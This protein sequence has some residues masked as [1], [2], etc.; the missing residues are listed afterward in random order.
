MCFNALM[1][2]N[3]PPHRLVGVTAF[4][5]LFLGLLFGLL[6]ILGIWTDFEGKHFGKSVATVFVLFFLSVVTHNVVKGYYGLPKDEV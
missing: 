1:T 5:V 2:K 4:I 3:S 6:I